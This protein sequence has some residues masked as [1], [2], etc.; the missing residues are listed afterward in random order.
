VLAG[1]GDVHGG[2]RREF[3][4]LRLPVTETA[5][6]FLSPPGCR[7]CHER[8]ARLNGVPL[9][10]APRSRRSLR[11]P[12]RSG[13][14]AR[15]F[16]VRFEALVTLAPRFRSRL[17]PFASWRSRCSRHA[18]LAPSRCAS[19]QVWLR[20]SPLAGF[21]VP[22]L[23]A[24]CTGT[25][26]LTSA[27]L[28]ARDS[29]PGHDPAERDGPRTTLSLAAQAPALGARSWFF[30]LSSALARALTGAHEGASESAETVG[31]CE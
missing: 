18:S 27:R 4:R 25:H 30:T 26:L 24:A 23:G 14:H 6:P 7:L 2:L 17:S 15:G 20:F 12:P 22:A 31:R 19:R 29:R 16:T 5:S 9:R 21:R 10:H 8:R 11:S 3:G 13:S 1:S 28:R